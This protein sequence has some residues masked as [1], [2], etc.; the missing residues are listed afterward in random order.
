MTNARALLLFHGLV[1]HRDLTLGKQGAVLRQN[2]GQLAVACG[3]T[4]ARPDRQFTS[5][6][7]PP[8]ELDDSQATGVRSR[9][10]FRGRGIQVDGFDARVLAQPTGALT[11]PCGEVSR[12]LVVL[13]GDNE[14][15]IGS[16]RGTGGPGSGGSSAFQNRQSCAARHVAFDRQGARFVP[17][18]GRLAG[19]GSL[20]FGEGRG[21]ASSFRLG[22][23]ASGRWGANAG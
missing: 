13:L 9:S 3:V 12:R 20:D 2:G 8:A 19:N 17:T 5:G 14:P 15:V 21:R 23:I 16:E 1:V 7:D 11:D 10:R 18:R 4:R 22:H 6:S